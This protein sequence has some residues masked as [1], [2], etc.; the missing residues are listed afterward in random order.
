MPMD[1]LDRRD[2][3]P[4]LLPLAAGLGVGALPLIGGIGKK[5]PDHLPGPRHHDYHSLMEKVRPG[6][7]LVG[8]DRGLIPALMAPGT[9][10]PHLSTAYVATGSKAG[11]LLDGKGL[12][13]GNLG[14]AGTRME[15]PAGRSHTYV[16]LRPTG[17]KAEQIL[18]AHKRRSNLENKIYQGLQDRGVPETEVRK[19]LSRS[20]DKPG[21]V[22]GWLKELFV[23]NVGKAGQDAERSMRSNAL[24]EVEDNLPKFLDDAASK[25][26][27]TGKLPKNSKFTQA[28]K[29]VCTTH[30]AMCGAPIDPHKLPSKAVA[31]D[32]LRAPAGSYEAVGHYMGETGAGKMSALEKA[33]AHSG[34]KIPTLAR[35][36]IGGLMGGGAYLT[37]RKLMGRKR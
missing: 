2:N 31:G 22:K 3:K 26:K 34:G 37:A 32:F 11:E 15:F 4:K 33:I 36:G 10:A 17:E 6:D 18:Q 28:V 20:Y 35:L 5:I 24:K 23:P 19:M 16:V 14:F 7:I 27:Q 30:A 8:G 9:A 1:T 25:F 29:G 13:V 12:R 21:A